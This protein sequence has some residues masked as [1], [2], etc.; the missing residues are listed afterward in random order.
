MC[1]ATG[2]V[3]GTNAVGGL[4]GSSGNSIR[5]G[6]R[7]RERFGDGVSANGSVRVRTRGGGVGGLVGNACYQGFGG[8]IS[9]SYATGMVSG[10]AGV[11]GLVGTTHSDIVFRRNYWDMEA[12][13]VRVGVG[14]DDLNENGVIDGTE[15][16]SMGLAGQ[17]TAALQ[18]PTDYEGIYKTWNR[19]LISM[20]SPTP[21]GISERLANIRH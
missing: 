4:V 14:E 12:S 1:Y 6:L 19:T 13:G 7:Y 8:H 16:H 20:G 9:T 17:T 11:G 10:S 21:A 18:T 3:S 15:S 2:D 5:A